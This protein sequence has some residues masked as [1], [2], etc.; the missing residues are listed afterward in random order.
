MLRSL[1]LLTLPVLATQAAA[2][3]VIVV[4]GFQTGNR[5]VRRRLAYSTTA[6]HRQTSVDRSAANVGWSASRQQGIFWQQQAW[7]LATNQQNKRITDH[8]AT[9][10]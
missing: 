1:T 6:W 3:C 2:Q 5:C 10:P 4:D 7:E 9:E 8:A